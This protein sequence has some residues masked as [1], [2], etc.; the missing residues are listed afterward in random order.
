MRFA[1]GRQPPFFDVSRETVGTYQRKS[2]AF[3]LS[4]VFHVK[5]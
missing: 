4:C 1:F 5:R 2:Q 3:A